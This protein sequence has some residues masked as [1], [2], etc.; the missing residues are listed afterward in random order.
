MESQ[1]AIP[2]FAALAQATRLEA[3]RRLVAHGPEGMAAGDLAERLGVP[4]NTLSA[5]LNVLSRAGLIGSERRSRSILYRANIEQVRALV[6]FLVA[7]C[8]GGEAGRCAPALADLLPDC[9]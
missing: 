6:L 1:E 2:A 3:F 7:D 8:C 9:V 5:H 4:A